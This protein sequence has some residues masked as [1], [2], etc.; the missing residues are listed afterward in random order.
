MNAINNAIDLNVLLIKQA[1]ESFA[2]SDARNDCLGALA[3]SK[4]TLESYLDSH[5]WLPSDYEFDNDEDKKY[6]QELGQIE[7][8]LV[9]ESLIYNDN[10]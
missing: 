6:Y 2:Q 8:K 5:L 4:E 1:I 9:A 3:Q 7:E 10:L